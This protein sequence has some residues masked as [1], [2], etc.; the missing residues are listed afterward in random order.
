MGV[1]WRK[2]ALFPHDY[3]K[4]SITIAVTLRLDFLAW[5]SIIMSCLQ[6]R[7]DSWELDRH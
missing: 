7:V 6:R 1:A 2:L 5:T 3:N 4:T